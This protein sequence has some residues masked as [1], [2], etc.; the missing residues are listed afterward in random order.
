MLIKQTNDAGE[1]I[2]VEV[3]NQEEVE[4]KVKAKEEELSK[5][6]EEKDTT[7]QTLEAEK[8]AL[9]AKVEGTTDDHPNFKALK[10]ALNAKGVEMDA[11]KADVAKDKQSRMQDIMDGKVSAAANGSEDME[12]KIK[13]HMENTLSGMPET[14]EVER[15]AKLNAALKL[16]AEYAQG[17]PNLLDAGMHGGVGTVDATDLNESVEFSNNEK[18]LGGKMGITAEDY[19]KYGPKLKTKLK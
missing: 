8:A 15:E 6:I 13:L 9:A 7:L 4:A 19:K 11:L 18:S 2:E 12:K 10:E 5:Q 17:E 1:E 3:F 16:S 14:N